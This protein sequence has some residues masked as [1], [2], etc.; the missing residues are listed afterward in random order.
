MRMP[1]QPGNES[2][3]WLNGVI[4]KLWPQINPELFAPVV[5]L[6]EDVMQ[7][8]IPAIVT[9]VKIVNI[10]QGIVPIRV[11][12][13]RWLD[14]VNE[15]GNAA[16]DTMHG[17]IDR[18]NEEEQVGEW[19][20]L[21]ATFSYRAQP[22]SSSARSKAKNAN[23]LVHFFMGLNGFFGA[24]LRTYTFASIAVKVL[25]CMQLFGLNLRD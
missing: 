16:K 19:A 11:L 8:S 7:A 22:S 20:S 4:S 24:P 9:Q 25:T 13:M 1:G 6:V 23:L 17:A 15:G 2:V 10:G 21:E 14:D 5:D 18:L 12:S 3:E